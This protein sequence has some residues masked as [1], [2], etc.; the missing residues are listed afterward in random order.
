MDEQGEIIPMRADST[1]PSL[2]GARLIRRPGQAERLVEAG[3]FEPASLM[4][5]AMFGNPR[6]G[7]PMSNRL[8]NWR[9]G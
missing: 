4:L 6:C 7:A 5:V 1:T 2:G 8:E 9:L 3:G